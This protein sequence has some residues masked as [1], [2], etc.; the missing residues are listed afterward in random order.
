MRRAAF[1]V[2][3]L[4]LFLLF[5][6]CAPR[7]VVTPV[8]K[9][10]KDALLDSLLSMDKK[11]ETITIHGKATF[12]W[13]DHKKRFSV[14]EITKREK[15]LINL[16]IDGPFGVTTAILWFCKPE[17]ICIYL[18]SSKAVLL[19]PLGKSIENVVVP[20]EREILTDMISG[21]VPLRYFADSVMDF[22]LVESG[23]YIT[24]IKSG[25]V[26]VVFAR[27]D[28]WHVESYEF[29]KIDDLR[30]QLDVSFPEGELVDGVWL[31]KKIVINAP[32]VKQK[33]EVEVRKIKLNEQLPDSLFQIKIPDNVKWMRAY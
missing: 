1:S 11:V 3:I 18:P 20:P 21:L 15:N 25:K 6:G 29:S 13:G 17:S 5:Y 24:F 10:S 23:V 32:S 30:G 28:P 19:E 12:E 8:P 26:L 33:I 7:K 27:P 4:M 31:P 9:I 22:E 16:H 2:L 14:H